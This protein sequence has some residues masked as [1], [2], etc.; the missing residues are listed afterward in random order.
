MTARPLSTG[1]FTAAAILVI[2]CCSFTQTAPAPGSPARADLDRLLASV[3]VVDSRGNVPGY[4]RDCRA[5]RACV[6]GPAWSD[7]TT[8]PGGHDGCDTRNNVLA[9]QLR[10]VRLRPGT[11]DCVVEHGILD[12]PYT[13]KQIT[14]TKQDAGAVQIDHV[15]PLAAAWDMG[16]AAWPPE[17]RARYANDLDITLLAVDGAQ[18]QNKSDKT[19][20][21]WLPPN[22]AYRC[23]FAGKYLTAAQ[24][25]GLPLTRADHAALTTVATTCP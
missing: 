11:H 10:E 9:K 18:N 19:P 25:Y 12:D 1:V 17:L 6:F 20:A 23:Y 16:A 21:D 14:F 24:H 5:G 22:H 3:T 2:S 13:G 15:Y 7:D 8:A 4:D